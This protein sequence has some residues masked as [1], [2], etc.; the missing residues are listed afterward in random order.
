[1]LILADFPS[2]FFHAP[3][4]VI[5]PPFCLLCSLSNYRLLLVWAIIS[6]LLS[7]KSK[8]KSFLRRCPP[9]LILITYLK[10]DYFWE[11]VYHAQTMLENM[12]IL[13]FWIVEIETN[14][15]TV[16]DHR[17][18]LDVCILPQE[19]STFA[20]NE[21]W[22]SLRTR[23]MINRHL[24]IARSCTRFSH[25]AHTLY[26]AL[27]SCFLYK[28]HQQMTFLNRFL[29]GERK[30][31]VDRISEYD[32]P[33]SCHSYPKDRVACC[34]TRRTVWIRTLGNA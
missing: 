19:A 32:T 18:R 14:V 22:G 20:S 33:G 11:T 3:F 9:R 8:S 17:L 31:V 6:R 28:V 16:N 5:I 7:A 27:I 1:M 10:L 2:R 21:I 30:Y 23:E 34:G 24:Y 4:W 15:H 13:T 29:L 25:L 12:L 26:G